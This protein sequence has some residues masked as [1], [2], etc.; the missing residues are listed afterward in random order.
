MLCGEFWLGPL[1]NGTGDTRHR[2]GGSHTSEKLA[3]DGGL[4]DRVLLRW[5]CREWAQVP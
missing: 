2:V 4:A 1:P 3:V 5:C